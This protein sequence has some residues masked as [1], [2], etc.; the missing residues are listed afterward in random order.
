MVARRR[1]LAPENHAGLDRRLTEVVGEF[2]IDT[3]PAPKLGPLPERR[4]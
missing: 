2:L 1:L 3:N 4:A